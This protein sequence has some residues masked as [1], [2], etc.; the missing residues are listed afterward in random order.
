MD[1][2]REIAVIGGGLWIF[3]VVWSLLFGKKLDGGL[4]PQSVYLHVLLAAEKVTPGQRF[5]E[6]ERGTRRVL[7]ADVD[8]HDH[9]TRT[10]PHFPG[11]GV[12]SLPL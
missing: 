7:A 10:F 2:T 11:G 6:L 3:L 9:L 12:F 4:S 1:S 8:F 5:P